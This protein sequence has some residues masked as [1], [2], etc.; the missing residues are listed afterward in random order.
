MQRERARRRGL[1]RAQMRRE[2]RPK[3]RKQ[4][5]QKPAGQSLRRR[6]RG[7]ERRQTRLRAKEQRAPAQGR[8][9][10]RT[11]F[12]M[13]WA[14]RR[15]ESRSVGNRRRARGRSRSGR[16][17]RGVC[18][19]PAR[20]RGSSRSHQRQRERRAHWVSQ[21]RPGA[22]HRTGFDLTCL[23]SVWVEVRSPQERGSGTGF[24]R[25]GGAP[26]RSH[27]ATIA[28]KIMADSGGRNLLFAGVSFAWMQRRG[29]PRGG[30]I[31][32][33]CAYG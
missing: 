12:G 20:C 26:K 15:S 30:G 25:C 13:W 21:R 32:S 17:G 16:G 1:A 33:V 7:P 29:L 24:D 10:H 23:F 14:Q 11:G 4:P 18:H 31:S 22:R 9:R 19:G 2:P 6:T 8:V 5:A 27:A 28:R 3:R